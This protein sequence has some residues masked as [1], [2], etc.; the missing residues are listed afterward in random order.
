MLK[1]WIS[2]KSNLS[3]KYEIIGLKEDI[4]KLKKQRQEYI[5]QTAIEKIIS[6]CEYEKQLQEKLKAEEKIWNE[7]LKKKNIKI[8][9]MK[10]DR[11]KEKKNF[12]FAYCVALLKN[13]NWIY[14]YNDN[15]TS[16]GK[17][18]TDDEDGTSVVSATIENK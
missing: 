15:T 5:D 1:T 9:L 16:N 17:F 4:R 18:I 14:C 8:E 13:G 3:L 10:E 6:E 2:F 11:E 12:E 7:H